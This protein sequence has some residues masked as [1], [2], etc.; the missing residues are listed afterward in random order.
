MVEEAQGSKAPMQLEERG[1]G[2]GIVAG[3]YAH[4]QAKPLLGFCLQ[5]RP[6]PGR[7]TFAARPVP[8]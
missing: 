5:R 6:D 4:H 1:D 2:A 8:A 7:D 3:D